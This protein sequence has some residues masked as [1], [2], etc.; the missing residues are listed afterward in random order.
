MARRKTEKKE[1]K[2][3]AEIAR[4]KAEKKKHKRLAEIARRKAEEKKRKQQAELARRKAEEKERIFLAE[5]ARRE[6]EAKRRADFQKGLDAYDREDYATALHVWRDLANQGLAEAQYYMG[7][8]YVKGNGVPENDKEAVKWYRLAAE[9]GDVDA[10][11]T[12][13]GMYAFGQGVPEYD[14]EAAKWYRLA[15]EQG[16]ADAQKE[17]EILQ[18]K[19]AEASAEVLSANAREFLKVNP[20]T[21]G[22]LDIMMSIA[23]TKT[24]L[25]NK[26]LSSLMT[27]LASLE[28]TLSKEK[29]YSAFLAAKN[30]QRQERL[31]EEKRLA[32][33]RR[34]RELAEVKRREEEKRRQLAAQVKI[35]KDN[36]RS[37]IAF[38]K[39]QITEA[40]MSDP[41]MVKALIPM[42]KSLEGGLSSNELSV[43]QDL[44]KQADV[45][46]KKHG[47]RKR[48]P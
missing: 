18:R 38:L 40:I 13:G 30:K 35:A 9:Q 6:A 31:A 12:L 27:A 32:E 11:Y 24:A 5:I 20:E 1:R 14:R 8:M 33:A 7:L 3:L 4:R 45:T 34:K 42:I 37:Y 36:L 46:L 19:F 25:K 17:L 23:S 44:K 47:L 39:N 21:P 29:G 16:D 15:A 10:Q 2:R 41:E 22:M 43:L 28:A 48:I 26:N